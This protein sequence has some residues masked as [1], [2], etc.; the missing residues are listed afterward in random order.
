MGLPVASGSN[1][2]LMNNKHKHL[3]E[4]ERYSIKIGLD[5]AQSFKAIGRAIGRD[6]TTI[7]KE[8][9][10]RRVPKQIGSF[11]IRFNNCKNRIGCTI[12]NLCGKTCRDKKCSRCTEAPCFKNCHYYEKETCNLLNRAP[13]VCNACKLRPKCSLE[14]WFYEPLSAFKEYKAVLSESRSGIALDKAEIERIDSIVTP[15]LLQGQSPHHIFIQHAS[16]LM[17]SERTLYNYIDMGLF[18]ARNIDL[19]RKVRYRIRKKYRASIKIDKA[20]RN[21]RTY[22]DYLKY[23]DSNG[24]VGVV[25]MDTVFG[26]V[27]GKALLTLHFV[28]PHFMLA[29][30]IDSCTSK[31]VSDVFASLRKLLGNKDFTT[32]IPVLLADNGSE[33]SDPKSIEL[34]VEGGEGEF[35][36]NLYYCDPGMAQQ[37]GALEVNHSFIRR[38]VPKGESFDMFTQQDILVMMNNINSYARPAL[39]D[40]TPYNIFKHLYGAKI[41]KKLG[42]ELVPPDKVNLRP[43]LLK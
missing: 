34:D 42:V 23:M 12:N 6:C 32:L 5:N 33:F 29:F 8:V 41:V 25:E 28:A 24:D 35:L 9:K 4:S 39:N 26:I 7:S 43:S 11:N 19:P 36:T 1:E 22:S 20:C 14:K 38:V 18:K 3:K 37:K 40:K 30:L 10:A 17:I 27:G 2:D 21:G 13:Y 15:L 16:E 31:S